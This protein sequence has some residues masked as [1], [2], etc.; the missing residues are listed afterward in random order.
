MFQYKSLSY[1]EREK[2]F[3]VNDKKWERKVFILSLE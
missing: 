2:N 1:E 3:D